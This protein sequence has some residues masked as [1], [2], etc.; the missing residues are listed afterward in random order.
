MLFLWVASSLPVNTRQSK[1]SDNIAILLEVSDG[2]RCSNLRL[3]L[4]FKLTLCRRLLCLTTIVSVCANNVIY[5]LSVATVFWSFARPAGLANVSL[6]VSENL[7]RF[8]SLLRKRSRRPDHLP[9]GPPS[10]DARTFGVRDLVPIYPRP[11]PFLPRSTPSET[12]FLATLSS[13]IV[14]SLACSFRAHQPGSF[15]L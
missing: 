12:G 3:I 2:S 5:E 1:W 7:D 4:E 9:A 15:P 6:P 13:P 10:L 8:F 14:C 11:V